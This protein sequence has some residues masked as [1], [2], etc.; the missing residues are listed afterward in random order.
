[1]P[2]LAGNLPLDTVC[3][4][5]RRD[6]RLAGSKRSLDR[7]GHPVIH[8]PEVRQLGWRLHCTKFVEDRRY[9]HE[10]RLW[11]P[12]LQREKGIRWEERKFHPDHALGETEPLYCP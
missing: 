11:K 9:I 10:R 12:T 5:C 1:M 6:P 7:L 3:D 2:G 4:L 8:R